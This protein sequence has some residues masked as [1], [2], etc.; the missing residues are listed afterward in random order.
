MMHPR[1]RRREGGFTLIE[2]LLVLV[3]LVILASFAV[4]QFTG[5]RKRA[6]LQAAKT[7]VG[8]C[9]S[10]LQMYD[11]SVGNYPTTAQGLPALRVRPQDLPDPSKWDGPYLDSDVPRDPWGNFFQY[12]CPG[13]H[14]PDSF[15]VWS[16]G[17]DGANGTPDDIGN[18][19]EGTQ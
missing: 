17:P 2:V 5:I 1:D 6:N 9:K 10:A 13:T 4:M 12:A 7:Q 15:D 16:L 14:N 11:M 8:L 18:W 3:I 19:Q